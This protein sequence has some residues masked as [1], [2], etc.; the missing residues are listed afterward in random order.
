MAKKL[1]VHVKDN[2]RE[3][4]IELDGERIEAHWVNATWGDEWQHATIET[5]D[6]E[7]VDERSGAEETR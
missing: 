6:F 2:P 5:G 4:Y 1:T 3:S 7:I